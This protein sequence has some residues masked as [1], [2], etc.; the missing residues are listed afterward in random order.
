M[1]LCRQTKR[2]GLLV[3]PFLSSSRVRRKTAY[4]LGGESKQGLTD[5]R[6]VLIHRVPG[7]RWVEYPG[8]RAC[9][10]IGLH[11]LGFSVCAIPRASGVS[12]GHGFHCSISCLVEVTIL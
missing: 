7:T 1:A 4:L 10:L 6:P 8:R 12:R 3:R 11:G 2:A 5:R 9:R